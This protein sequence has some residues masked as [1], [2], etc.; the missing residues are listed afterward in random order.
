MAWLH[1]KLKFLPLLG[2][3]KKWIVKGKTVYLWPFVAF[4]IFVA[5]IVVIDR[6]IT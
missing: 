1:E 5:V 3:G 6:V 4:A 2:G